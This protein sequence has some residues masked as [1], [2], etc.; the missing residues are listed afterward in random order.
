VVSAV[1]RSIRT[2]HNHVYHGFIQTDAAINPGNSGGPLLNAEGALIGI[3]AAILD[4]TEGIGFAI[5]I[6]VVKRVIAELIRSGEVSPTWVGLEFQNLDPALHEVL[7]LPEGLAGVL[8]NEVV[9]GSPASEAGVERGDILT[10]MDARALRDAGGFY[11]SFYS[12]RTGQP[13]ELTIWREGATLTMRVRAEELPRARAGVL[14]ERQL[15]LRLA[16]VEDG[17]ATIVRVRRGSAAERIGFRSGDRIVA[18]N[19][20]VLEDDEA[21][22][23]ATGEL[24]WQRYAQVAV[25]RDGTRYH[26]TIP[27]G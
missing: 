1:D 21:L 25:V 15:G 2:R 20:R 6:D 16:A 26:V 11:A 24:R 17:A 23:R 8:V 9:E 7:R 22:W 27:L 14:A 3:N 12:V 19:G 5:P 10:H 13:I 4:Q 18:I